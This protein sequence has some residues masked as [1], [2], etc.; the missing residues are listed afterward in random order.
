MGKTIEVWQYIVS[1]TAYV[2]ILY[3]LVELA[4]KHLKAA[5][6]VSG[7]SLLAFPFWFKTFGGDWFRLGK[8]IIVLVPTFMV[9]IFRINNK[10]K[11][12]GLDFFKKN[13]VYWFLYIVLFAN[14][15]EASIKDLSLG[16][17]LN[18]GAGILCA[19]TIPLP[20]KAWRFGGKEGYAEIIS[21][22]PL[23]WCLL[24]TTWNAGF[25]YAENTGF[26]ASSLC[27]LMVPEIFSIVRKR[28]DLWLHA[29]VYTL[30]IHMFI[31]GTL[32]DVFDPIMGSQS[33]RI[34][35][36]IPWIGA[37]NFVFAIAY[38]VWWFRKLNLDKKINTTM[39]V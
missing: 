20:M 7:L 19:I 8:V 29:R 5:T 2:A 34:E 16:N 4:R 38:T 1:M 31:R 17:Y 23:M 33:W 30:A 36:I 9:H 3:V 11:D 10:Y 21:D 37:F 28:S 35:G 22:L 12:K 26:F 27:I 13:W 14:I 39:A 25:V 6:I 15:L 24:Y 32:G 18:F